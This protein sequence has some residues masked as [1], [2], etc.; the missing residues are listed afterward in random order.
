[1][2]EKVALIKK[3]NKEDYEAIC[4]NCGG[5]DISE[6]TGWCYTHEN[7]E[8][9]EQALFCSDDFS[10]G[11]VICSIK[12]AYFCN[13][14]DTL[15]D[16]KEMT[17][18]NW[19]NIWYHNCPVGEEVEEPPELEED[20]EQYK[21]GLLKSLSEYKEEKIKECIKQSFYVEAIIC[22]HR[23]IFEQ[24]RYLLIVKIMSS[25]NILLDRR[26]SVIENVVDLLK[27]MPDS[28][29]SNFVFVYGRINENQKREI[30][31]FNRLRNKFAHAW[32]KQEREKYSEKQI[33]N[34]VEKVLAIENKLSQKIKA[35][36]SPLTFPEMSKEEVLRL[37]GDPKLQETREE[38]VEAWYY[39]KMPEVN[40]D[41]T[42]NNELLFENISII[43]K[44][45]TVIGIESN[46]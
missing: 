12:G 42:V 37:L 1:M 17:N 36:T 11:C 18:W 44:D 41:G 9:N 14:C 16:D 26:E 45:N 22:L 32:N 34:I 43:F 5:E 29:L 27:Y 25:K 15:Y 40:S 3:H 19:G 30:D 7:P 38:G 10:A 28:S 2:E 31:T 35:L 33:K 4:P 21:D 39:E 46:E 13:D 24:L 8:I 6:V 20:S 23:H